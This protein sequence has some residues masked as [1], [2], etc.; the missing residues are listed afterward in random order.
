MSTARALAWQQLRQ[1]GGRLLLSV[2]LL[3]SG[4]VPVHG[5]APALLFNPSIT[6]LDFQHRP[7]GRKLRRLEKAQAPRPEDCPIV[8]QGWPARAGSDEEVLAPLLACGSAAGFLQVQSSVDMAQVLQGLGDWSAVRLGALGPLRDSRAAEV[9]TLKRASFLLRATE[10]YGAY[11]QV[12]ALFIIHSA[13]DDELRGLLTLLAREKQLTQTLGTMP[14]ALRELERRGLPLSSFAERGEQAGDVLRGLGR[15]G[16][17]ALN[18]SPVSDGSRYL[19]MSAQAQQMPWPYQQAQRQL[20][21]ALAQEH[22]AP[23][24]MALG[25]FDQLT[26]GVPLGFYLLGAGTVH[27]LQSLEQGQYEQAARE[28]RLSRLPAH[29]SGALGR[30]QLRQ[31]PLALGGL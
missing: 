24:P 13:C 12:F 21:Q 18:T 4:C 9:L 31:G 27:G 22:H 7:R 25:A 8:P 2:V 23:G 11:A 17:E 15:A 30:G 19:R 3:V 20:E 10:D 29:A 5:T 14:V 16:R 28:E 26:F 1:S 6:P